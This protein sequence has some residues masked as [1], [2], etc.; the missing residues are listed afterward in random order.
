M[1][2]KILKIVGIVLVVLIVLLLTLP[3]LF[4][5][6]IK[7]KIKDATCMT[8]EKFEEK[9]LSKSLKGISKVTFKLIENDVESKYIIAYVDYN[10][11]NIDNINTKKSIIEKIVNYNEAKLNFYQLEFN[12]IYKTN[13]KNMQTKQNLKSEINLLNQEEARVPETFDI[14]QTDQIKKTLVLIAKD[15]AE[16][17]YAIDSGLLN[18]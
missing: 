11:V 13:V 1:I 18:K 14:T 6:T 2:K 4:K 10:L 17:I 9:V 8:R 15:L 7:E 12:K 16:F 5:N 3:F